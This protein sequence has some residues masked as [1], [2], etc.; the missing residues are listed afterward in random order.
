MWLMADIIDIDENVHSILI[1]I[2]D[3]YVFAVDCFPY[4]VKLIYEYEKRT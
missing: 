3:I 2:S 4:Y 1:F